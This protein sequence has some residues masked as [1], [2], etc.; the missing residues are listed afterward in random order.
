[1]FIKHLRKKWA[2]LDTMAIKKLRNNYLHS[3]DVDKEHTMSFKELLNQEQ[4]TYSEYTPAVIIANKEKT[5]LYLEEVLKHPE[6]WGEKY[7]TERDAKSKAKKV[8]PAPPNHFEAR[9]KKLEIYKLLGVKQ[10]K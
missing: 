8:W 1:M 9:Q 10:N 3:W 4:K 7:V 2:K 6:W 5:Q